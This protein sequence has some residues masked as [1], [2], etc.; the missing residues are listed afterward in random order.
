MKKGTL[1]LTTEGGQRKMSYSLVDGVYYM[2]TKSKTN[3][4]A[5]IKQNNQ[6]AIDLDNAIYHAELI[7][8]D[9]NAYKEVRQ[10][11]LSTMPKI[12]RIIFSKLFGRKNDMFIVLKVK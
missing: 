2:S 4:V 6:V 5:Q 7:S 11:Y 3:K 8:K 9:N 12:Q 10:T 1:I